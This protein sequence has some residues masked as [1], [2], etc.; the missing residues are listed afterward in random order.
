MLIL[1]VFLVIEGKTAEENVANP[2][3][4]IDV[5]VIIDVSGSMKKNDP[6]NLRIPALKLLVGLLPDDVNAGV[7]TFGTDVKPLVK[8]GVVNKGWKNKANKS[9]RKITSRDMFT[10]VEAALKIISKDWQNT[11]DPTVKRNIILLTDGMVDVSKD[12]SETEASRQ[13]ILDDV[14]PDLQEKGVTIH[15]ISLSENAD[16]EIMDALSKGTDGSSEQVNS[17]DQLQR[18]FL[19]M[20]EKSTPRDTV[21][22]EDNQFTIDKM[23]DEFTLLVFRNKDVSETTVIPPVGNKFT[24]KTTPKNVAWLEEEG[25]DLITIQK[26]KAGKWKINADIDPDNRVMVVSKLKLNTSQLPNSVFIGESYDYKFWLTAGDKKIAKE[27]F[28]KLTDIKV[29]QISDDKIQE[30]WEHSK[31]NSENEFNQKLGEHFKVGKVEIN[32]LVD[33]KTFKRQKTHSFNVYEQV[34]DV[35]KKSYEDSGRNEHVISVFPKK[36]LVQLSGFEVSSEVTA[37]DGTKTQRPGKTSIRGDRS[38][39]TIKDPVP[40]QYSLAISVVA[41]S[42]SGRK[43]AITTAPVTIGEPLS[44]QVVAVEEGEEEEETST[45]VA[46]WSKIGITLIAV[47]ATIAL[48]IGGIWFFLKRKRKNTPAPEDDL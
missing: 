26:P 20:F 7:W 18:V 40:G 17:A 47:N 31:R 4:K 1:G 19:H 12:Q 38:L 45:E 39:I 10:D 21:P 16:L 9:V 14:L 37:P 33:G 46:D 3:E 28:Y 22:L 35:E 11:S 27:A 6:D 30:V 32:V 43:I 23:I 36:E 25:Y 24:H 5:R 34:Y 48:L 15:T 2:I 41:L 8:Y 42:K 29:L 44:D 13:R